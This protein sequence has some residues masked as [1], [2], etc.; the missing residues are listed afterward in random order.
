M[1]FRP[2]SSCS[3]GL[4]AAIPAKQAG[5]G[6]SEKG[7]CRTGVVAPCCASSAYPTLGKPARAPPDEGS[8]PEET[9]FQK[10][11]KEARL[12]PWKGKGPEPC[13]ASGQGGLSASPGDPPRDRLPDSG[14]AR[15]GPDRVS[16]RPGLGSGVGLPDLEQ[17]LSN[18][19]WTSAPGSPFLRL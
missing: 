15:T 17:F 3:T 19:P 11:R 2:F 9:Q 18:S 1:H 8:L 7:L 5:P 6:S 10:K 16:L 12:G 4:P 14:D 13:A